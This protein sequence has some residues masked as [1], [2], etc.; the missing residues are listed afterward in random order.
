MSVQR[1]SGRIVDVLHRAEYPGTI[2]IAGGVIRRIT[3]DARVRGARLLLPGFVDAHIH[4]ESSMLPPAEFGPR[5]HVCSFGASPSFG[6]SKVS[7]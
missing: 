7:R 6:L 4:I 3:R 5:C 2:E 1:I